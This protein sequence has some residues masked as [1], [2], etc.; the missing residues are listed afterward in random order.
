MTNYSALTFIVLCSCG[1][2]GVENSPL[3]GGATD[4]GADI[5]ADSAIDVN[6][7]DIDAGDADAAADGLVDAASDVVID[8]RVDVDAC[9]PFDMCAMLNV[10]CG[11]VPD[12]C[13]GLKACGGKSSYRYAQ[14]DYPSLVNG[15]ATCPVDH[16]FMWATMG[17]PGEYCM[18]PYGAGDCI[19]SLAPGAPGD[20]GWCCQRNSR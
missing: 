1:S 11:E 5:Q 12:G 7:V 3:W 15:Q 16:P 20:F 17:S 13:G 4:A 8:A 18:D 6:V 10:T 19:K 9:V 2:A 14:Y